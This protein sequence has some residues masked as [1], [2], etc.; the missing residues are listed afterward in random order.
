MS[1]LSDLGKTP[2]FKAGKPAA[3]KRT[4][5]AEAIA[6]KNPGIGL[7]SKFAIATAATKKLFK[8]KK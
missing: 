3:L 7:S 2:S 5:I 4:D 1:G 8:K 6:K